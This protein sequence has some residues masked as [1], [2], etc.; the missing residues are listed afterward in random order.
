[1]K[2]VNFIQNICVKN[3]LFNLDLDC[4]SRKLL[5]S[6]QSICTM[7][8]DTDAKLRQQCKCNSSLLWLRNICYVKIRIQML[9]SPKLESTSTS[10]EFLL[11]ITKIIILW[12]VK[13]MLNKYTGFNV[14]YLPMCLFAFRDLCSSWVISM[15]SCLRRPSIS[16]SNTQPC[17][18]VWLS[19]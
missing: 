1:M 2:Q 11:I 14:A 6:A 7:C 4:R 17:S 13:Q 16:P 12:K 3:L 15:D 19:L 10:S 8:Q 5:F 9:Y 18:W